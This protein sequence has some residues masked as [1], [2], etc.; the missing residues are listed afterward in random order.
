VSCL[1]LWF[2][3]VIRKSQANPYSQQH[4]LYALTLAYPDRWSHSLALIDLLLLDLSSYF[5]PSLQHGKTPLHYAAERGSLAL[6]KLL[7][8][9]NADID[10]HT[11]PTGRSPLFLAA[12]NGHTDVCEYLLSKGALLVSI[13]ISAAKYVVGTCVYVCVC[14]DTPVPI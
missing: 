9:R 1:I 5:L 3:N 13:I 10:C 11:Y 8:D 7:V 4:L 6:C 2:L 14:T 12:I